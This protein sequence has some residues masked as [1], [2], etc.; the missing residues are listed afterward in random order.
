MTNVLHTEALT[1]K[2][3]GKAAVSGVNLTVRQGDIY[4]LIGK[5]GAGKT[6]LMKT[7]CGLLAPTSGSYTLFDDGNVLRSSKRIGCMIEEPTI[8]KSLSAYDNLLYYNKLLGIT[9][10]SNIDRIL[11]LVG[12][13]DADKKKSGHFSLGMKQRLALG[14]ALLGDPDFLI[15]DEPINGL[16]PTGIKEVRDLIERLVRERGMTVLIS[17]HILGELSKLATR[18]GI[19]DNGV[20]I[21]EFSA[22]ELDERC[23]SSISATVDDVKKAS[24]VLSE[25]LRE[26]EY[27]VF[28]EGKVR[29]YGHTDESAK[30]NTML[31]QGGVAV[32]ELTVSGEDLERYFIETVGGEN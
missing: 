20:L 2:F 4:G 12:L 28:P 10:N 25:Y 15:L 27:T 16:D 32:S 1:K 13:S 11:E 31:V 24:F 6:T 17:S 22:E 26:D 8:Y 7:V 23:R 18:Y 30:I 5:N 29:V 3:N 9:D 21:D 19:I 14:I